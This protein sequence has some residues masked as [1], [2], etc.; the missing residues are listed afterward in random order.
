MQRN[1]D[2]RFEQERQR[3][4]EWWLCGVQ[5]VASLVLRYGDRI[6]VEVLGPQRGQQWVQAKQQNLFGASRTRS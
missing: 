5:K 6:A 4:L 3:V 1:A 2:A